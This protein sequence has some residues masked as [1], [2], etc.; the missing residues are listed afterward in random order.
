[1]NTQQTTFIFLS[2]LIHIP[3]IDIIENKKVGHTVD[4]AACLGEMYLRVNAF[5]LRTKWGEKPVYVPWS[6]VKKIEDGKA[7][8][9]ENLSEILKQGLHKPD[10]GIYL[11]ETFWDKQI[12]DI[13]GSKVVRVNDLHLL[14]DNLKLWLVH[15]D[16]GFT[17][18]LRRLGCLTTV[19][20]LVRWLSDYEYQDR[21]ISWK[22]VQPVTPSIGTEALSLKVHHSKLVELHPAELADILIDLG[23]EER[24]AILSGLD[25]A[26]TA[27]ILQELPIKI[28]L[29][30][31]ET[32]NQDHL[33]NVIN[34]MP[35]DEV[36]D[37]LSPLPQKKIN[38][39]ISKFP[40]EK[41]SQ[42]KELLSHS[43]RIAGSIMNTE[44]ITVRK[45]T[46]VS[47]VL[48]KVKIESRK[49]EAIYYTY[50]LD[51]DDSVCGVI[52]L[53]QL[54]TMPPEKNVDEFMRK[55]VVKVFVNTKINDVAE[56]F[57]KYDF[58]VVPVV[59]EK[60]KILGIITMKDAFEA[61]FREI[62]DEATET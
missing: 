34:E 18:L 45:N 10:S 44:F 35:I 39:L 47:D 23:N 13:A 55:R 19:T 25:N 51:N 38:S 26:T 33:I 37:L 32:I 14:K 27:H 16:I 29:Q 1:M 15:M 2:Q 5:T 11:K 4:I 59:D 60:K 7:L 54:L 42:I 61:V 8:Y 36:V 62:R 12:V 58:N 56:I 41:I 28:R 30:I 49:K 40:R 20:T 22:F 6:L 48:Q 24:I 3:V 50:I 52:T 31:A 43:S 9:I 21:L 17:G 46:P 57:Y 53:R